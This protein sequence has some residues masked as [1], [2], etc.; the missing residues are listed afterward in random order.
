MEACVHKKQDH[1]FVMLNSNWCVKLMW[2]M[3]ELGFRERKEDERTRNIKLLLIRHCESTFNANQ[4]T[5]QLNVPLST[6]GRI[7]AQTLKVPVNVSRVICSPL[8]R[9]LQ[10]VKLSTLE[11]CPTKEIQPLCREHKTDP[12]DFVHGELVEVESEASVIHRVDLFKEWLRN[13]HEREP[14]CGDGVWAIV[15]HADFFFYF[16]GTLCTD[17]GEYYGQ[18][19]ENGE[20]LEWSLRPRPSPLASPQSSSPRRG[21]EGEREGEEEERTIWIGD[22][23]VILVSD[24]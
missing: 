6:Q 4:K 5:K 18:W 23:E 1:H 15:G 8:R 12:C 24:M 2:K 3:G 7:H 21:E 9:C 14:Q 20:I 16:T 17:D 10:T 11:L 13:L 22:E 19:L